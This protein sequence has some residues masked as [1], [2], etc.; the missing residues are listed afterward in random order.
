MQILRNEVRTG[1]LV[2]LTLGLVVGIV[3]YLSSPGLFKPLKSFRVYFDNAAGIK[4]GAAVML[5]GR[6]IGTVAEIQSPVPLNDRPES[7][8]NYEAMVGVQV[9][10][11]AQIY[12]ETTVS[13]RSFGL[14]AELVID[15]TNGNP[16]SG[17]AQPN[18]KFVGMRAPDLGEVGPLIIQKLEPALRQSEATLA[19]LQKT[20][21]NLTLLT[22]KDS[23]FIGA[24]KNLQ[25]VGANLKGMTEKGGRIDAALVQVH[26]ALGR[27]QEVLG[28][29]QNI[30]G[31]LEKDN[32]LQ[33][34]LAN[35]ETSSGRLK[36]ILDSLDKTLKTALPRVDSIVSDVGQLTD[37]LK[38]QPWRVIW[39]STIK[40]PEEREKPSRIPLKRKQ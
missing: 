16:N 20:S 14:L 4:P 19:E 34:T 7:K 3:L 29:V 17:L 2:I 25:D 26:D 9:S 27:V 6:K 32:N 21:H 33:K 38:R 5:A 22:A 15:F 35:F 40:Y 10:S 13:M 12:R 30:T 37:K 8:P 1:L 31:Q 23:V 28:H 24:L 11:D 39:P 36:V 18:E